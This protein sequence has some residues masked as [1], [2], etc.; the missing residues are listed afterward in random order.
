VIDVTEQ[1]NQSSSYLQF[2]LDGVQLGS[3]TNFGSGFN[4]IGLP[5]F[6]D[7]GTT[8]TFSITNGGTGNTE[9]HVTEITV[10]DPPAV[11]PLSATLPLFAGGLGLVGF[12][13]RRR[14]RNVMPAFATA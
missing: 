3:N 11:K 9:A 8:D 12:L 7:A 2:F 13:S 14:K 6:T 5:L 4:T 1:T 10:A